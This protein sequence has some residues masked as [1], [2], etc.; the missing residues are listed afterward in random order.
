MAIDHS[1]PYGGYGCARQKHGDGEGR[2]NDL[3]AFAHP[4]LGESPAL[5]MEM[6]K[7]GRYFTTQS[8]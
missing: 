1:W 6:V 7:V 5:N 3:T 4:E 8:W 2:L